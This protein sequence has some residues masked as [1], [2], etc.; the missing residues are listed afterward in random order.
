[1]KIFLSI[2]RKNMTNIF[3]IVKGVILFQSI[4]ILFDK[5]SALSNKSI[6][7]ESTFSKTLTLKYKTYVKSM[8]RK[9]S[10]SCVFLN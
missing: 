4:Q 2:H 1:M 10:F 8:S 3:Q 7:L 9:L 5:I 6:D